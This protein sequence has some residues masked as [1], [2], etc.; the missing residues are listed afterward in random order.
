M[1]GNQ[2]LIQTK[3]E[4]TVTFYQSYKQTSDEWLNT[5]GTQK[6]SGDYN[7]ACVYKTKSGN[8][9]LTRP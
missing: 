2:I 7:A 9:F 4:Q 5:K 8:G 6:C 1:L 3:K